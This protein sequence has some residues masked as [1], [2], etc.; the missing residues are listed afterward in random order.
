MTPLLLVSIALGLLASLCTAAETAL[1]ALNRDRLQALGTRARAAL[2][3]RARPARLLAATWTGRL[4]AGTSALA[5]LAIGAVRA[6][7]GPTKLGITLGAGILGLALLEVAGR[8]LGLRYARSTAL[9]AGPPVWLLSRALL[10]MLLPLEWWVTAWIGRGAERFPRITDREIR[11]LLESAAGGA[12]RGA[13]REAA[14]EAAGGAAAAAAGGAPIGEVTVE[15][16]ERRLIERVFALDRTHAWDVMT[17]RVE[18]VAWPANRTLADIAPELRTVPYS[19]IPLYGENLD[20]ITGIL[21]TR[22]A[23]QAL[24]SGQRDVPLQ[25]LAREPFFVPGSVPLNRL[26]V[27]FQTRRIHMGIVIDEYGGLDGLVTLEDV[28]EELVGEIVDER[29]VARERI[30]RAGRSEI[31]VDGSAD[32]REINHFWNTSFPE[33]EHRSLNGYV[34]EE[35]GRVPE[36]GTKLE[37][38]GVLIEV[39]EASDTQVLRARLTRMGTKA[40]PEA[41]PDPGKGPWARKE[42]TPILP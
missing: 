21:Y 22:D 14:R 15:E 34:L 2:A 42:G 19:R 41:A 9:L 4:A 8:G 5:V 3:L 40:E 28:L 27:D 20:D 13:A 10:P 38:E 6:Q 12:A 7:A 39:L 29:D 18:I 26:L 33:L 17:P 37:R 23:Y 11:D 1:F 32:L 30:V 24:I 25:Q 31:L 35:L 16:H 36:P